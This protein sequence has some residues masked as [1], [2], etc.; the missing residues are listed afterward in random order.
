MSSLWRLE[1]GGGFQIFGKFVHPSFKVV[2]KGFP[3]RIEKNQEKLVKREL[4]LVL[5]CRS[6]QVGFSAFPIPPEDEVR[7]G[8]F[9]IVVV[10]VAGLVIIP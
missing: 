5:L 10:R 3:G 7:S 9:I 4:V 8:L 1:F 6:Q 2:L